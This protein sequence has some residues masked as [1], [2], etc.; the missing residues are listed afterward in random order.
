M[1]NTPEFPDKILENGR[2]PFIE[3]VMEEHG[4]SLKRFIFTYV[5]NRAQTD[6]IFQDVLFTVYR[7]VHTFRQQSSF[8]TWL[9]RITANRC[10]DY[11]RSPLTRLFIWKDQVTEKVNEET[12]EQSLI[13]NE[14]KNE[15]IKA[16][17]N[18][19]VKYREVLILQYYQE[20]SIQEISNLL[21]VNLSTVK[22]RIMR[23]KER[24]KQELKEEFLNE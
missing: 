15:T 17:M 1:D 9:Y 12:P 4:E 22:T 5:K 2:E 16:I 8:K 24:L 21:K 7:R 18:L 6:D 10:R 14:R 23:A 13:M 19:P 20:F 3:W 11:L